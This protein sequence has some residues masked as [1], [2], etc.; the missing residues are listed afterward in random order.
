MVGCDSD[1]S[2]GFRGGLQGTMHAGNT[3]A[4]EKPLFAGILVFLRGGVPGVYPTVNE[5]PGLSE[6]GVKLT[7]VGG[8]RGGGGG[9]PGRGG[10]GC[11]G[12]TPMQHWSPTH[13]ASAASAELPASSDATTEKRSPTVN[14]ASRLGLSL[15]RRNG[16]LRDPIAARA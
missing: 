9:S 14:V 11:D 7:E 15:D 4:A 2:F 3:T 10:G 13:L 5:S 16:D 8:G 6:S 12:Q 1:L